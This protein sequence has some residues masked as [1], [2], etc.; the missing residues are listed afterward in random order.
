MTPAVRAIK[1]APS[2]LSAD[3]ANLQAEIQDVLEGGADLLHLDVMDG[4]FVPN[5]TFGP[6]VVKSIRRATDA[7]LDC[8]LMISEPTKY[9]GRES[10]P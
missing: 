4:H 2:L 8:H 5:L 1:V 10:S 9:I 6:P 7:V 3:F